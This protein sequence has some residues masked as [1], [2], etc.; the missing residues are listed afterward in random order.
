MQRV[1]RAV[2]ADIG[3]RRTLKELSR[4]VHRSPSHLNVMFSRAT[5][6]TIR[7]YT[8]YLRMARAA[9]EVRCGTKIQAVALLVG[10]RSCKNFYRQFEAWFRTTPGDFRNNG[11]S[12]GKR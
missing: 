11:Q 12:R 5:G 1:I 8:L 6:L 2:G 7:Q 4:L 10:F 3:R 9:R